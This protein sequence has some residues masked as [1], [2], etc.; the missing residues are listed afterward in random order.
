MP[1]HSW[2]KWLVFAV[3]LLVVLATAWFIRGTLKQAVAQIGERSWSFH[4]IWLAA[5]GGL[6]L[7]GFL[8]AC[9]YWHYILRVL[10]QKAELGETIYAYYAGHL[11][12]YVPGKA[13]VVI[14]RTSLI[15]SQRV[16][17]GLAA[18]SVFYET[19]TMMTVGAFWAAAILSYRLREE[20]TLYWGAVGLMIAAGL[21]TLPPVFRRLAWFF[22]IDKI[23]P[24]NCLHLT[25]IRY[26]TMFAGWIADTLTWGG[27]GLSL[28]ALFQA[29]GVSDFSLVADFPELV[30]CVSLAFVAGFL[31]LIPGG[32]GVRDMILIKLISAF[33]PV[34]SG[35]ATVVS[36]VL[37][38]V[39][40]VS[41]LCFLG[42][43][44][45]VRL[46]RKTA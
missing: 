41:E 19:L 1:A 20:R 18:V 32:L 7:L 27:M 43:L 40:V 21:P 30:A 9:L 23:H 17:V 6:Y 36:A 15:R 34:D 13:L 31:S 26:R 33:F 45:I 25:Q 24:E 44:Y 14:L 22:R 4:P 11:G 28:W 8:P 29:V 16:D 35:L 39:W 10:R 42:I 12:K 2:K 38:I 3:K 46:L 5:S 37:R